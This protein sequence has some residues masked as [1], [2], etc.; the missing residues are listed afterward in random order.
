MNYTQ[1]SLSKWWNVK[2]K[3]RFQ[4]RFDGYN[5]PFKQPNF[6]NPSSVF[7]A[8]SPGTFARMTGVQGSYSN[9]GGGRPSYYVSGRFQF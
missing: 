6:A 8:N 3:Y 5:F 7:N 9:L 2:E 4:V 1:L